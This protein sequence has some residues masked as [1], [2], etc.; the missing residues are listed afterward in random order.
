MV[1]GSAGAATITPDE[2]G[3]NLMAGN[4]DCSLREAVQSAQDNASADCVDGDAGSLDTIILGANPYILTIPS[5]ANE[6][7]NVNGDLDV[8]SGGPLLIRGAGL[9]ATT[10]DQTTANERIIDH[11]GGDALTIED[12]TIRDGAVSGTEDGGNIKLGGSTDFTL[13]R[14]RVLSG[15]SESLGGGVYVGNSSATATF[16]DSLLDLN[17]ANDGAA[18]VVASGAEV[19]VTRTTVEDNDAASSTSSPEGGG[20]RSSGTLTVTDSVISGNEAT[21]TGVSAGG[22]GIDIAGGS[23]TIRRSLVSENISVSDTTFEQGGGIRASAP[24]TIVNST[25]FDNTANGSSGGGL[26]VFANSATLNHVTFLGNSAPGADGDHL[27]VGVN[28]VIN[29]RA[30]LLPGLLFFDACTKDSMTGAINSQGY[31]IEGATDADCGL[32]A[33]GDLSNAGNL[34]FVDTGAPADNG[35]ATP[36]FAMA[37]GS[38]AVDHV[39]TASCGSAE[40]QDQRGFFRPSGA[41]CDSGAYERVVCN[42][43]VQEGPGAMDCPPVPVITPAVAPAA[44]APAGPCD[45]L[46]GKAKK[47]CLCKQKK[48]KKRKK[49]LKRLRGRK[50]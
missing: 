7:Q 21:G 22:G 16:E 6:N 38:P 8:V 32:S 23:G 9:G 41:A 42:G 13:R 40:G 45:A 46:S 10:I 37:A 36:T 47:K 31:N 43:V 35:G 4:G 20:I 14:A 27:A 48:G 25:I 50:P 33:T 1:P 28:G 17:D 39:P 30:T 44:S 18:I 49:C 11:P 19:N 12:L 29:L 34:G 24:A 3:D 2:T 26:F 5:T 15:D